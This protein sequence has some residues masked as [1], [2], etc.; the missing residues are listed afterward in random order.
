MH[1]EVWCC[2][3]C[4]WVPV[5]RSS[6]PSLRLLSGCRRQALLTAG[7]LRD[8]SVEE[9]SARRRQERLRRLWDQKLRSALEKMDNEQRIRLV[10]ERGRDQREGRVLPLSTAV[11]CTVGVCTVGV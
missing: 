2:R 6:A 8:L 10:W 11:V 9:R 3:G 1:R 4:R 7:N 5:D